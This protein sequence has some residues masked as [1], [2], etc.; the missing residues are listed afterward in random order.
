M[1]KSYRVKRERDFNDIFT[2]GNNIA[3]R[4]FVVYSLSK[5][6]DHF[7]VGLSVSKKLGNAV[8]RN[9]IK[10]R[11]RHVLIECQHQLVAADFVIIARKGV[12]ELSYQDIKKNLIHV[13]KLAK[14]YQEGVVI[15]KEN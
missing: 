2:K 9:R 15:E 8:I 10:R 1:K 5:K 3:N 4:K 13:L 12:E 7:R 6:Q 11:L 14:L